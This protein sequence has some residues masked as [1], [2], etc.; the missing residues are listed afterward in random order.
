MI[1]PRRLLMTV[2]L[3]IG[4]M[5]LAPR[6]S[7][8]ENAE[9]GEILV[10]LRR[11]GDASR[12]TRTYGLRIAEQIPG[13][14]AYRMTLP[15][16][17]DTEQLRRQL[18]ADRNVVGADANFVAQPGE[19][20][21]EAQWTTALD[22][23][24]GPRAYQGQSSIPLVNF[25]RAASLATG[26][27]VTVA[28]LDTGVSP[29]H[30]ALAAQLLTGWNFIEGSAD[31]DDVPRSRDS[32][33]N[34]KPDELVGHGTFVAGLIARFAPGARLLP[35]KIL[36]G[37]GQGTLWDA[38]QGIR[39]AISR[40]AR[41]IN[42]SFGLQAQPKLLADAVQEAKKRGVV[43]VT[44]A[45]NRNSDREQFP[46]HYSEV[47]TVAA[48]GPDRVKAGF[49]NFGSDVD[50]AAPGVD[51]VSTFWNGSYATWSGTSFSTAIV[52]G[53]AALILSRNRTLRWDRVI[54]LIRSTA[55]NV[56]AW[57]PAH[58]GQLGGS[59][60]GLIDMDAAILA[61]GGRAG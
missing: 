34:G 3:C 37:D 5:G 48:L 60:G 31:T 13:T 45:G 26:A 15:P 46:A 35:V 24:R 43:V 53:Q 22:G 1:L 19:G 23:D 4:G 39:F 17:A 2:L 47:L 29:R 58:R 56:D 38:V 33:G 51:V 57:N 32:N 11:A 8:A 55:H 9:P 50:V 44:S 16:G 42:L 10:Q 25:G 27:G 30:P 6:P 54:K 59:E 12:L 36:D 21:E 20:T 41:V 61:A 7:P 18:Q 28:V 14:A 40:G 52:S 49:S